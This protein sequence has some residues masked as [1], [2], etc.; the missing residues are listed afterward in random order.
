MVAFY[1]NRF[2]IYAVLSGMEQ[3]KILRHLN[4]SDRGPEV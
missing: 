1:R 2:G 3:K 4:P